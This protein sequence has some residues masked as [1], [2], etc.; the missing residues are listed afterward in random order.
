L[1][2]LPTISAAAVAEQ[3]LRRRAEGL[4]DAALIDHDHG[5]LNGVENELHVSFAR[6]RSLRAC[7]GIG[8]RTA[9]QFAAPRCA[10]PDQH[11]DKHVDDVGGGQR[12]IIG[13]E[14]QPDQQAEKGGEYAGPHPPSA[15]ATR[16]AGT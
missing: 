5:V 6:E 1:T 8:T 4:H 13:N 15:D 3:P 16:M 14:E 10:D 2:F 7:R 12:A 9:Q 11:E